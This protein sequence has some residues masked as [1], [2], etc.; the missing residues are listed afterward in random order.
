MIP[1]YI[2]LRRV[3]LLRLVLPR[4]PPLLLRLLLLFVFP[5]PPPSLPAAACCCCV[6]AELRRSARVTPVLLLLRE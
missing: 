6:P 3:L 5:V 2:S 4:L 1:V